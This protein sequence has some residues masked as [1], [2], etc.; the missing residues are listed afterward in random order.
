MPTWM[1]GQVVMWT[2]LHYRYKGP[3]AS[4]GKSGCSES[5]SNEFSHICGL[6]SFFYHPSYLQVGMGPKGIKGII[7]TTSVFC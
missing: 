5:V 4:G 1:S 7:D 2:K 3:F 6:D